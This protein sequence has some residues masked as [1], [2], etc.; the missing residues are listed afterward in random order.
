M[1]RYRIKNKFR[2]TLFAII[3]MLGLAFSFNSL[4]GLD[5]ASGAEPQEYIQVKVE[6][7]DT[8]WALAARYAPENADL[9]MYIYQICEIN[10]ISAD[11]LYAGSYI[12]IPV[13]F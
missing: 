2:F 5:K 4:L 6:P 13:S 12:T 1:G 11:T 7:G 10:N 3:L 8:L 9:R